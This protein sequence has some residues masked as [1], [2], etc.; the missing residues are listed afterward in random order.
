MSFEIKT[1]P[2]KYA[3][4]NFVSLALSDK[5]VLEMPGETDNGTAFIRHSIGHLEFKDMT[6]VF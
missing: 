3:F 1:N 6:M 2:L 4:N 5:N